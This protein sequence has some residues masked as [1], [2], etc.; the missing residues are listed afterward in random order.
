MHM[1]KARA[2]EHHRKKEGGMHV[3]PSKADT[4]KATTYTGYN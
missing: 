4:K 1:D 3:V 2:R